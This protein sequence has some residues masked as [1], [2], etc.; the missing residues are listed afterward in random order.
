MAGGS[1]LI[2]RI[3]QLIRHEFRRSTIRSVENAGEVLAYGAAVCAARTMKGVKP[4]DID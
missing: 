3:S 2:P 4:E 1:T